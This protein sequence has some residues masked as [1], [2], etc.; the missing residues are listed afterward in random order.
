[1]SPSV[2]Q[3]NVR[4]NEL[5]LVLNGTVAPRVTSTGLLGEAL[6]VSDEALP[7]KDISTRVSFDLT[8]VGPLELG[9]SKRLARAALEPA[10]P[11]K[12]RRYKFTPKVAT[13]ISRTDAELETCE[14]TLDA[15][16]SNDAAVLMSVDPPS[17][18]CRLPRELKLLVELR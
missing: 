17:E 3:L 18:R 13:L 12:A 10:E 15:A 5:K 2:V 9:R 16:A 14:I 8:S 4:S 7:S 1:M 11:K 6:S